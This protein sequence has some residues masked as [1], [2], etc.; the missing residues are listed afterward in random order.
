MVRAIWEYS[1]ALVVLV[2][3][4]TWLAGA[5]RAA[6]TARGMT[7]T[8]AV[9][10][11]VGL[12]PVGGVSL[13]GLILSISPSLSVAGT[14]LWA[15]L[16]TRRMTG[17]DP[18][19]KDGTKGLA[20]VILLVAAPVYISFI[21]GLGPDIYDS[22]YGFTLWD[23]LLG[24]CATVMFIRG[25]LLSLVLIACLAAH[26]TGL[27]GSSNIFDSLV[28]APA[29]IASLAVLVMSALPS[30]QSLPNRPWL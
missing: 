12:I 15:A 30:S 9:M 29:L 24:A 21:G 17:I 1:A 5:V 6:R 8:A 20:L 25:S 27:M 10:A 18:L 16:A 28:D 7:V 11:L 2:S 26:A 14:A 23:I 4:A 19:G 22:G 13:A 3:L